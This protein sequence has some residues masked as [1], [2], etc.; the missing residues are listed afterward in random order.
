MPTTRTASRGDIRTVF[1]SDVHIGCK[2]S[3]ADRFFD[4]L[5]RTHPEQLYLVGDFID[6]WRL[7][8]R[9]Y[10]QPV[11]LQILLRLASL[12]SQG[13]QICYTLGNHDAFLRDFLHDFGPITICDE[14]IH[15]A[16]NQ[17]QYLVV[18]GDRF[19]NIEQYAQWLSVF[20][21]FAYDSLIWANNAINRI[22]R[23]LHLQDCALS[24][25][26]K[27]CVKNAVKFIS[28]FERRLI[29]VAQANNCDGVICGHIHVPRITRIGDVL[30]CNT[31]DWVEHCSTLVEYEDGTLELIDHSRS[32]HRP[33]L[34][35]RDAESCD[36]SEV[37]DQAVAVARSLLEIAAM[38][39]L[40]D[41][42][43]PPVAQPGNGSDFPKLAI[44]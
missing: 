29:E 20:G 13:T 7:K 34:S 25:R 16:A 32:V 9:W 22:R 14:F 43:R 18:H 41:L 2:Y 39:G 36:E 17:K 21:A 33:R 19:D 1:V 8:K 5:L 28:D 40:E 31:G 6:G 38:P 42:A 37:A 44:S 35:I 23:W 30:Y 10:W 11:Y 4:F 26:M 27:V 15:V 24:S 12:A 3:Q